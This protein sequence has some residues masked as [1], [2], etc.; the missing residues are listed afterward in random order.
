MKAVHIIHLNQGIVLINVQKNVL[1]N[2]T[3]TFI[4]VQDAATM[5]YHQ[6]TVIIVVINAKNGTHQDVTQNVDLLILVILSVIIL[7]VVI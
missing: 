7:N 2:V 1:K 5:I 6:K 4:A 3:Q